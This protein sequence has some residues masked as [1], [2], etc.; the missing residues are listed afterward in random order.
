M[1][2]Y[3]ER[4]IFAQLKLSQQKILDKCASQSLYFKKNLLKI[5]ILH[6]LIHTKSC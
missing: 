4:K 2:T 1:K 6:I 5:F 3:L